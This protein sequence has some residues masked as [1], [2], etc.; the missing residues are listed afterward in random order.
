MVMVIIIIILTWIK[1]IVWICD[2]KFLALIFA[3]ALLRTFSVRTSYSG[4]S[5]QPGNTLRSII[6]FRT[7]FFLALPSRGR[8]V[9][10]KARGMLGCHETVARQ[11]RLH[12][13]Q[14][15]RGASI[16][17]RRAPPRALR[18][19]TLPPRGRWQNCHR[20]RPRL[21]GRPQSRRGA[22]GARCFSGPAPRT[23][24]L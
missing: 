24:C 18:Q 5:A 20:Q 12:T 15:G 17:R 11:P 3:S 6:L 4:A 23:H 8:C 16:W 22:P 21:R 1:N 14:T 7:W 2:L 19:T 10:R 9:S 13:L